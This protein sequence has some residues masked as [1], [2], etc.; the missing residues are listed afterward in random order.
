MA[1]Q[2]RTAL[3]PHSLY[4]K[5][6]AVAQPIEKDDEIQFKIFIGSKSCRYPKK[7]MR[8][9]GTHIRKLQDISLLG[10]TTKL[11]INPYEYQCDNLIQTTTTFVDNIEVFLKY[12]SRMA[13]R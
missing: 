4:P 3:K 2:L 7:S 10:E 6:M 1:H 12:C 11:L 9:H 13:D 8:H 5:E